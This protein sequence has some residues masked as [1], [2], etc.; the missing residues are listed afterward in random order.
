MCAFGVLGL[1]CE[2]LASNGGGRGKKKSEIWGGPAEGVQWRGGPAEGGPGKTSNNYNNAKPTS[3]AP[4]AGPFSQARFRVWGLGTT[5]QNNNT[6]T[7]TTN[8][9]NNTT[10]TTTTTQQQQQKQH[11]THQHHSNNNN[12]NT[13][14]FGQNTKIG[15]NRFGQNRSTL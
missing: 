12:N 7:T 14:K 2:A 11:T 6:I 13:R 3:G 4:K 8:Q 5:T 15:Q 10:A 1:S 9:L